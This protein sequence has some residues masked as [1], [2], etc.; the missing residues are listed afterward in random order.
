MHD[1]LGDVEVAVAPSCTRASSPGV[2]FVR[3]VV[4]PEH[5][6]VVDG[7][8]ATTRAVTALDAAVALG[9]ADGRRL[10]DRALQERVSLEAVRR[11]HAGRPRRRGARAAA[12]LLDAAADRTASEA[13]RRMVGL[14]AAAGLVA[15]V[16]LVV[17]CRGRVVVLDVAFPAARVAVEVRGWAFHRDRDAFVHDSRRRNLLLLDGWLVL[18]VSWEDLLE[19]PAEVL[20]EIREAVLARSAG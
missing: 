15:Q 4:A 5:R 14:L 18:E 17:R 7:L 20:A 9:G 8:L 16:N 2:R 3:R 11:A 12:L 19:R 13:E 10:L 1:V 6:V